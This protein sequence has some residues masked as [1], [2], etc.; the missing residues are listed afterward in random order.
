MTTNSRDRGQFRSNHRGA[1]FAA[2]SE[3]RTRS[4]LALGELASS[5]SALANSW[6]FHAH[7]APRRYS[8]DA[9]LH[10]SAADSLPRRSVALPLRSSPLPSTVPADKAA[11]TVTT[12][13]RRFGHPDA[14]RGTREIVERR[15]LRTLHS[16]RSNRRCRPPSPAGPPMPF[17]AIALL[18][19]TL[20]CGASIRNASAAFLPSPKEKRIG[21]SRTERPRPNGDATRRP[22]PENGGKKSPQVLSAPR[23]YHPMEGLDGL[24]PLVHAV[25]FG[26]RLEPARRGERLKR[27]FAETSLRSRIRC[28]NSFS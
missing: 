14:A 20:C 1:S 8:I 7:Q 24:P 9:P 11:R 3:S 16:D 27:R 17:T 15:T 19:S 25:L 18:E 2:E 22:L 21:R 4:S 23:R 10:S 26:Q 13:Q 12:L 28:G 5:T 6:R